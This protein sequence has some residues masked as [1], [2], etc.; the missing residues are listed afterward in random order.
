MTIPLG[1]AVRALNVGDVVSLSGIMITARD[2]AHKYM[3]E[4]FIDGKPGP[5][6]VEV[7]AVL[8]KHLSGGVI[9]PCGPV[10]ARDGAG[11]RFVAAGPTT[12]IREEPYEGKVISRFGVRAVVGKGGMGPATLEACKEHGCV[13]LHTVGGAASFLAD[14]VQEVVSV[15]KEDLG[16]PEAFWVIRVRGFPAVVT[17]D[18]SGNSLHDEIRGASADVFREIL[19][20]R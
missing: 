7:L 12:S 19:G 5:D 14:S 13:Y 16:T 9:Y 1:D 10:V 18:A 8:E 6:D 17:M 2:A 3:I 4:T 15:H 11:W 20:I